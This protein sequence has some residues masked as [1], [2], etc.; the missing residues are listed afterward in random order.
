MSHKELAR[1]I[2]AAVIGVCV[3]L[4]LVCT[5]AMFFGLRIISAFPAEAERIT[6]WLVFG[7]LAV[8]PLIAAAV[9]GLKAAGL[10]RADRSFSRQTARLIKRIAVCAFADALYFIAANA[11]MLLLEFQVPSTLLASAVLILLALSAGA[12]FAAISRL[13]A[14]AAELQEE[15]EYT[16]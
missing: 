10:V 16:V 3:C 13:V 4:A 5:G 15:S 8:I 2:L 9:F 11:V 1:Y 6:L 14:K 12:G 7:M